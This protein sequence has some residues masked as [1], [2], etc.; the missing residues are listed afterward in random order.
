M[1]VSVC[2]CVCLRLERVDPCPR[3]SVP[4]S[5]VSNFA[6]GN[7]GCIRRE[8]PSLS[9]FKMMMFCIIASVVSG[10]HSFYHTLYTYHTLDT[11]LVALPPG[12][13]D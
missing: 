7:G 3:D 4:S 9:R 8:S 10:G 6:G 5:H 2:L 12:C 13:D 11:F 1:C